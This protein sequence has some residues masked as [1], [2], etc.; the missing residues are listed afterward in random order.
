MQIRWRWLPY[1]SITWLLLGGHIIEIVL[2]FAKFQQLLAVEGWQAMATAAAIVTLLTGLVTAWRQDSKQCCEVAVASIDSL[3]TDA[4]AASELQARLSPV[5]R[6]WQLLAV[7][8]RKL[9][10]A[11]DKGAPIVAPYRQ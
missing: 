1:R 8:E 4:Q 2:V 9:R 7:M 6:L 3:D 5:R 11:A 10:L